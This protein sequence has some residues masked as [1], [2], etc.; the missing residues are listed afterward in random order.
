MKRISPLTT[1]ERFRYFA[2]AALSFV[3]ASPGVAFAQTGGNF[4]NGLLTWVQGNVITTLGTLSI[5][6]VGLVLLS[7]RASFVVILSVCAGIWVIFNA[8]TL[9]GMLQQ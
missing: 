4:L 1:S 9:A 3:L 7:M 5:I 6:V 2:V 8:S